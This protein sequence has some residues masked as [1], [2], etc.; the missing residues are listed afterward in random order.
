MPAPTL[1]MPPS[2]WSSW[3]PSL[4]WCVPFHMPSVWL[5]KSAPLRGFLYCLFVCWASGAQVW[6]YNNLWFP[7][8]LGPLKALFLCSWL[9]LT[10]W[11]A[12]VKLPLDSFTI[13][14]G[15]DSCEIEIETS[16]LILERPTWK[17]RTHFLNLPGPQCWLS[18]VISGV[19]APTLD[20]WSHYCGHSAAF[21][22]FFFFSISIWPGSHSFSCPLCRKIPVSSKKGEKTKRTQGSV[23]DV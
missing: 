21:P 3:S 6:I 7:L 14:L 20:L 16:Q 8:I 1:P 10:M 13:K 11:H 22:H 4:E 12:P 5:S 15:P 9:F 18:S 19:L 2:P 23:L 17:N